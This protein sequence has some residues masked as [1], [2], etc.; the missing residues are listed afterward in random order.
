VPTR[1]GIG[2]RL[3]ALVISLACLAVLCVAAYLSP[4]PSGTST[5]TAL[6]F[7]PCAFLETTHVPCPTCGMTTATSWFVRGHFVASLY[8]QPAGFLFAV[9][10][11]VTFWASLYIAVSGRPSYRMLTR[12]PI[13]KLIIGLLLFASLSWG[14][15]IFIHLRGINGW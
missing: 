13:N 9:L 14:W 7:H 8:T 11:A 2:A 10:V 6:G 3:L 4:S 1:I 5:H 15:K 12:L